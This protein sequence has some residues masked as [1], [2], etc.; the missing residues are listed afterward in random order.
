MEK[1]EFDH[2]ASLEALVF[3]PITYIAMSLITALALPECIGT[4][5][6]HCTCSALPWYATGATVYFRLLDTTLLQNLAK[7]D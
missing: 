4:D 6:D 3:G 7:Y 5:N 1:L 2:T